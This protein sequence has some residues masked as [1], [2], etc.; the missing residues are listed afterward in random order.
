MKRGRARSNDSYH[1]GEY[2][3]EHEDKSDNRSYR[4]RADTADQSVRRG[5]KNYVGGSGKE[6]FQYGTKGKG[7]GGKGKQTKKP[8]TKD[9]TPTGSWLHNQS[10]SKSGKKGA[11]D[12]EYSW[13]PSFSTASRRRWVLITSSIR[14]SRRSKSTII[15]FAA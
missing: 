8:Y 10:H 15:V 3:R 14:Y 6:H 11:D 13:R 1:Y 7:T 4:R 9:A 12:R 5:G 2:N